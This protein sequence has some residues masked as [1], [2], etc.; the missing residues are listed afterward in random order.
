LLQT[1]DDE[2]Q[3][4]HLERFVTKKQ[5]CPQMNKNYRV[6]REKEKTLEIVLFTY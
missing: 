5:K 1:D 3:S 6:A 4:Y 2:Q